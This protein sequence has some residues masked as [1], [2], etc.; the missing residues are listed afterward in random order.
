MLSPK[1]AA[2]VRPDL[3]GDPAQDITEGILRDPREARA[4]EQDFIAAILPGHKVDPEQVLRLGEAI[5]PVRQVGR[6]REHFKAEI[7]RDPWVDPVKGRFGVTILPES[8][9]IRV[10]TRKIL[11]DFWADPEQIGTIHLGRLV[12]PVRMK[13]I[14]PGL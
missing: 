5:R 1:S 10:R 4:K 6:V 11:Q 7:P 8:L 3:P 2:E 14:L 9:E 12:D 13:E